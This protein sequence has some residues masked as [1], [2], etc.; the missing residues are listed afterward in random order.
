MIS[1]KDKNLRSIINFH[2]IRISG[3]TYFCLRIGI[4]KKLTALK[5]NYLPK[6]LSIPYMPHV[7]TETTSGLLGKQR[8]Q[9]TKVKCGKGF[10]E[11][12]GQ[13]FEQMSPP[14]I[15]LHSFLILRNQE[16]GIQEGKDQ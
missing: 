10:H 5:G 13:G 9:D 11:H 12:W 14:F 8:N 4:G 1:F 15:G 16:W 7:Q 2:S 6:S 3:I